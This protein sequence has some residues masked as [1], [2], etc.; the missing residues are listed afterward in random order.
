MSWGWEGGGGEGGGD[1]R[2][3]ARAAVTSIKLSSLWGGKN[4]KNLAGVSGGE[5]GGGEA[6]M[7]RARGSGGSSVCRGRRPDFNAALCCQ[8]KAL[9]Y[10]LVIREHIEV[11]RVHESGRLSLAA[12]RAGAGRRGDAD[13]EHQRGELQAVLGLE[14]ERAVL[15]GVLLVEAAQV[16]Q[17]LDHLGVEE[18]PAGVVHLDVGLQRLRHVVLQLLDAAVVVDAGAA[19]FLQADLELHQRLQQIQ[20]VTRCGGGRH[21]DIPSVPRSR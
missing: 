1:G 19:Q 15:L 16:G 21:G 2:R 8:S 13:K 6:L 5:G 12:P 14:G 7:G 17:L 18:A 9:E 20:S 3:D 4:G 11:Y 10:N